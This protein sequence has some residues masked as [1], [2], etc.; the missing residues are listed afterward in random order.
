MVTLL[1]ISW[2]T[3]TRSLA[4]P[5]P[6]PVRPHVRPVA[7]T[8]ASVLVRGLPVLSVLVLARS[9]LS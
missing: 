4:L 7:F 9:E 3:V 8:T 1:R 2:D 6:G 5:R